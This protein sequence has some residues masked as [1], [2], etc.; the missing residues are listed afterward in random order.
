MANRYWVGGAGTW[1]TTVTTNW[2]AT[3]GGTGGASAP[4]TSDS[5]FFDQAGTYTVTAA[6]TASCLDWTVSAGV[7]TF[8]GSGFITIAGSLSLIAAGSIAGISGGFIFSS[9]STGRTITTNGRTIAGSVSFSGVGGGWTLGS[10]FTTTG[11]GITLS[12]GTLDTGNFA[13]TTTAFTCNSASTRQLNLGS[14]TFTLTTP[15]TFTVTT[16]G[17]TF[18]AGTS[19]IVVSGP[20]TTFA[21]VGLTFNNIS[22]TSTTART[23]AITGANTFNNF[24]V[25][26]PSVAGVTNVTF[27]SANTINGTL[28]TTGTAGNQRVWFQSSTYGIAQTLTINS[29]PSL[30]DADFRDLYIIGTAAPISGTRIGNL[31]GCSGITFDETKSVYWNLAGAQNWSANGWAATSGGSPSTDNFPLAQDT[32][33][34]DTTG[35]VTGTITMDS[36]IPY[37][38]SIDMSLRSSVST[39]PM[40]L[41]VGTVSVYGDFI[42]GGGLTYSAGTSVT[43]SGRNTQTLTS[44][45]RVIN[46]PI[47]VDS[48]GGTLQLGDNTST[49]AVDIT[50]TNGTF[51]TNN[52]TFS[53][54]NLISSNSNVRGVSLGS[55][56]LTLNGL[57][58]ISMS[59]TTNLTFDAGT[60]QLNLSR[61][62]STINSGGLTFYN[63]SYTNASLTTSTGYTINGINTFNNLTFTALSAS[64]GLSLAFFAANQTIT[65]TLTC[66]GSASVRRIFLRSD[67]LGTQRT[68]TVG[69]LSAQDCD[70][71]DI[72]IAGAAASSSPT[73]AGNCGGNSGITFPGA[74][75]VYWNLAAA[76]NWS[77]TGWASS[78][79]GTPDINNFP[80]AQDTAVFDSTGSV[81]GAITINTWWNIGSVNMSGR[82]TPTY[83]MTLTTS[84]NNPIVYG[85]WTFDSG[86]TSSSTTGTIIFSKRGTQTITSG[87]ITFGCPITIDSTTGTTQLADALT[88]GATRTLTLTSGTFS[89]ITYAVSAGIVSISGST[90]RT[91]SMGTNTW[92]LSG[93]GTVWDATTTTNLNFYKSTANITLSDTSTTARTFN[94]GG[95]T[96]NIL[97]IGGS[98][99]ISTT[100]ITGNNQFGA[101]ASTKT[102]AHTLALG[103]TTQTLGAWT[104]TGTVGN[105]VTVTGTAALTIAGPRVSG[106]NYLAMGTTT[107]S[108]TSPG[109]FYGGANST[110]TNS[111]SNMAVGS[112]NSGVILTAAPAAVT[113]YWVGGQANWTDVNTT[114]WSTSSGG[115][116]GASVPT[117][118]DA[119]V[120]NSA[121]ASANYGANISTAYIN[122]VR[123]A[124]IT[125]TAPSVGNFSFGGS[126]SG[127]I[128]IHG[129]V[130]FAASG[131]AITSSGYSGAITLAGNSSYTFNTGGITC[132]NNI[133][134]NGVGST[135]TLGSL[136]NSASYTLTVTNGT[137]A[138]STFALTVKTI[139]ASTTN[140][141]GINLG[142]STVSLQSIDFQSST[143]STMPIGLTFTAGTSSISMAPPSTSN[144]YGG[145]KT[146][147]NVSFTAQSIA[148]NFYG[149]NTFNNLTFTNP[150]SAGITP[151]TFYADQTINA[152]LT[153]AGSASYQRNFLQ[154]DTLGT[155]RTLTVTTLAASQ[156]DVD[157]RDI[158]IAGVAAP[159]SGTRFGDCKG[160]SGITFVAGKTVYWNLAAGGN[161]SAIGWA[162]TSG[163]TAAAANFPLAQDT[164]IFQSTGL[165]SGA[166]VT[167]NA[168]YNIGT[169]DMSARTSNTMTLAT[170]STAFAIY[171]NWVD[172]T[173][174]TLTG[175]GAMTFAGRSS[176]T[177][178]SAGKTFTQ[179]FKINTIGGSVTLQDALILGSTAGDYGIDHIAGTFDANNFNLT[180]TTATAAGGYA[181]V[182]SIALAKTLNI[183]SGTWTIQ[184]GGVQ[185]QISTGANITV[186]GTGTISMTSASSKTFAGSSIS[187]S[188]I[189][190]DQG[191]AG[192]LTI[193]G[194]NTFK[195]ITNTYSATGATTIS[196]SST[197]TTVSQFTAI[198]AA[199]NVL[200]I[201]GTSAASPATL[202]YTGASTVGSD[203]LTISNVRAYSL[204]NTWYAGTN[205]TNS[206][207][208]GWI[209]SAALASTT[210]GNFFLM[211]I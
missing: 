93:T 28:S 167:L 200:T 37:T 198:G 60:S 199:G 103:A 89:A 61:N 99:G 56:T 166:T 210:T 162:A 45:S 195:N 178:T 116:G 118:A 3:S 47:I 83:P 203:Y 97:T 112:T 123:C 82:T 109:E 11:F 74:K 14:S 151:I 175:T 35:S 122:I 144:F 43:F 135:W 30:T 156:A 150:A 8:T 187:Y 31:R 94:G 90:T 64:A 20:S 113:R 107:I 182:N 68:L 189:T 208:L 207:S 157:F 17:F 137:F 202:I 15:S 55:S 39:S 49:N 13:L 105:I 148:T 7:V 183:G 171:G 158:A 63:V 92:T 75:T 149:A 23:L 10:S 160:N 72:A 108:A 50:I 80:L 159:I 176:Q 53:C 120:F 131:V 121:S 147:Y 206:G 81:T 22:F 173:G 65:G 190:L 140:T 71:R 128:A 141:V 174:T 204:S 209:F 78:S 119:V 33:V 133:T 191:G 51:S 136:L 9:T 69:T 180:I 201:S 42:G 98:T 146:F 115:A 165:N 139:A 46:W 179:R 132:G 86:V 38:G 41:A 62:T 67:T 142:S 130:S 143:A 59:S 114:S 48:I 96:Y 70:F 186:T 2:S 87:G 100:T 52:K 34:F 5:V 12:N 32:A 21:G 168:A 197:S 172:G 134:V 76:Q 170:G 126:G 124:S 54:A 127:P 44:V 152:T 194:D 153:I 36:A 193:S 161:W 211:F 111:G 26:A 73:R 154:S 196:F 1:N 58:P 57:T 104:I 192:T 18:N 145:G 129:S 185:F 4:T 19:N 125:A 110:S 188:G 84:G 79:G 169:I 117:S 138:C 29:A 102:V 184:G 101:L 155:T 164:A 163:G 85:D 40:T 25:T 88:I 91:L 177:I 16:S 181:A 6:T 66:A 27:A 106:V 95:L 205:S 24:G 77:A